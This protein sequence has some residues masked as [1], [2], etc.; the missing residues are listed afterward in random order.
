MV[1]RRP[2]TILDDFLGCP[3]SST[4]L[5]DWRSGEPFAVVIKAR[6][7]AAANLIVVS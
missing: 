4:F 5:S 3:Q 1:R 2:S 6:R 7:C